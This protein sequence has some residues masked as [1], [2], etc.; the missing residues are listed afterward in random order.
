M[1]R[2]ILIFLCGF[3]LFACKETPPPVA[4]DP[5]PSA[6]QLA[7]HDMEFYAFVHF[8]M[9][10]FTNREWG[11]GAS[12]R[13]CSILPNWTAANGRRICKAAGMK[14]IILTAKHHDGFCLWPS[15]YTEHSVK[16]SPWENG[17]G[18]V[19]RELANACKEYG[20][21]MGIYLSP[22]D[23]N[24]ASYG[25]PEYITYYRN[26]LRELLTN[27]GDIFEVWLDGAN[28]GSGYYGGANETRTVD[29]KNYYDW[30]NTIK[31]VRQLQ[32]NAV[33]FSDAGPD[34]RWVGNESGFADK[35]NWCTLRR[36]EFYPGSPNS[37]E[38]PHGQE[39]GNYWVPAE[40]DVSIR[41]GWFY[42]AS[43]DH[44]VK[45]LKQLVDIYY[46]SIGRNASFLLNLPVD[47]RGLIHG[48]DSAHLMALAQQIKEDFAHELA[49]GASIESDDVRGG[50]KKYGAQNLI[51]GNPDTYWATDDGVKTGSVMLDF[52]KP[53]TFDRFLV[54]EYIPLGQ[55][56][57]SF[58]V[59]AEVDGSWKVV[60][61]GT[62][63]GH[64]R[65]LRLDPV[66][67]QKVRFTVKDSKACPVISNLEIYNAPKL[68]VPPVVSR[69]KD[70]NVNMTA[71]DK[72][73]EIFY[74]LD[75]SAPD[76]NASKFQQPFMQQDK[77]VIQAVAYDPGL[78]KYSSPARE[79]F[80]VAKTGWRIA[81]SNL[82]KKEGLEN[83]IDDN[84]ATTYG[85]EIKSFPA[86]VT[87]DLG[88]TLDLKG[89]S[90]LPSQGR[91]IRGTV[92]KYAFYTSTDGK[93]WGSPAAQG[94][95]ANI[96]NNPIV[97]EKD[98]NPRRARYVRFVALGEIDGLKGFSAAE[99][100]VLTK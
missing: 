42:H 46:H 10:T 93:H 28:G 95:F 8:N 15:K 58:D 72:G 31:I 32:P 25:T 35:T 51:D 34:V 50:S 88:K 69:D 98:F 29:R 70:G 94:E 83:V 21:K 16:N 53:T 78:D 99:I 12:L 66:T 2:Y 81:G 59:E 100:G 63:I 17:K 3:L 41:P 5:V 11:W 39:D 61:S 96:E 62:T 44:K 67:A 90:Y 40:V 80:D 24:A 13:N 68:L 71:A 73:L 14:G 92:S 74:T 22:W 84:P 60:A 18:D 89:F 75:G 91:D 1:K 23:R 54:Q 56:V 45:S 36:D 9:N 48:E 77:A 37:K 6:R 47:R 30:P 82:S 79:D 20:L 57:K 7:W 26:Q 43:E 49:G 97:Q 4:L 19:V 85:A 64:K 38:L 33:I 65:I 87:I 27:Y 76:K 52:G 86:E 55:R